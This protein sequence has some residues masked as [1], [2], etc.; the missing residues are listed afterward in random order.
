MGTASP[1]LVLASGPCWKPGPLSLDQ[2]A[3]A[4][5]VGGNFQANN[6]L[7]SRQPKDM[8]DRERAE[9]HID[10]STGDSEG[11]GRERVVMSEI[12][13]VGGS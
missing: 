5:R 1:S 12:A 2:T 10:D 11:R 13:Y 3:E 8:R 6:E 7:M 9:R 4:I